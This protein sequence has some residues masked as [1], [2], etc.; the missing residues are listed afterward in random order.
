[1]K[2][3]MS[4][5]VSALRGT[6]RGQPQRNWYTYRGQQIIRRKPVSPLTATAAQSFN[7]QKFAEFSASWSA[8][9][10][11]ERAAWEEWARN[12]YGGVTGIPKYTGGKQAWVGVSWWREV[13][14]LFVGDD[15]P[16]VRL[17]SLEFSGLVITEVIPGQ[18]WFLEVDVD[19]QTGETWNAGIL[20]SWKA[21]GPARAARKTDMA[22]WGIISQ[23]Q[24]VITGT[25]AV[26]G[27]NATNQFDRY[28]VTVGDWV[29]VWFYGF[30]SDGWPWGFR[31]AVT[32]VV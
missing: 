12:G 2:A 7:R 18:E 19:A 1:V 23:G 32:V 21:L 10:D 26:S 3:D 15:P 8:L 28:Q 11:S 16:A 6:D 30:S 25:G 9:S 27:V 29:E 13:L 14:S 17:T 31:K 22:W 5:P 4:F 24:G 20:G